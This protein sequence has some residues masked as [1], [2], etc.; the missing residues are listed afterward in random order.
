MNIKQKT[1]Q[2][3]ISD[4]R[5]ER[6]IE[7]YDYA[8]RIAAKTLSEYSFRYVNKEHIIHTAA[9]DGLM[10][11]YSSIESYDQS[12]KFSTW[13][14]T[15]V[16]HKAQDEWEKACNDVKNK[17]YNDGSRTDDTFMG[18]GAMKDAHEEEELTGKAVSV[19][20]DDFFGTAMIQSGI[21]GTLSSSSTADQDAVRK[22]L[23]AQSHSYK[24]SVFLKCLDILKGFKETDQVILMNLFDHPT[25]YVKY[26]KEELLKKGLPGASDS[27]ENI[28][29]RARRARMELFDR[30]G[31]SLDEYRERSA[32]DEIFTST[33][34]YS[35]KKLTTFNQPTV[36]SAGARRLSAS[37]FSWLEKQLIEFYRM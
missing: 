1:E 18:K 15:I 33:F 31:V 25:G 11:A 29:Q 27:D 24:H 34:D 10:K 23:E 20:E 36:L 6:L 22:M 28:R 14:F 19:D 26:A 17:V 21:D 37:D 35:I 7:W 16:S 12:C 32:Q 13:F 9:N 5:S 8:V 3:F 2:D 4:Y 30:V